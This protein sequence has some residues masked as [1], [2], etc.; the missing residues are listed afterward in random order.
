MRI[1]TSPCRSCLHS[2]V[3]V[4]ADHTRMFR[5]SHSSLSAAQRA[6]Y[7]VL[8]EICHYLWQP[9]LFAAALTCHAWLPAARDALYRHIYIDCRHSSLFELERTLRS[10]SNLRGL[11][12]HLHVQRGESGAIYYPT[13][14]WLSFLVSSC[15]R[16]QL[17]CSSE[18]RVGLR[19]NRGPA[20]RKLPRMN[21][22]CEPPL[23]R[24]FCRPW[25][26]RGE[27]KG[28]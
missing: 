10:F 23:C 3:T 9:D 16:Q 12:R 7:H 17:A 28:M 26:D 24:E 20:L 15:S 6:N 25:A 5:S 18:V 27:W 21:P 4:Q 11:V 22:G 1:Q 8:L 14:A 19:L 13:L 2:Q